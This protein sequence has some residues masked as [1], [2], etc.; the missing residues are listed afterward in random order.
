MQTSTTARAFATLTART[1]DAFDSLSL[2]AAALDTLA[3]VASC[4]AGT[5]VS[6]LETLPVPSDVRP[7]DGAGATAQAFASARHAL[8][9]AREHLAAQAGALAELASPAAREAGT[10]REAQQLLPA[11]LVLGALEVGDDAQAGQ[12]LAPTVAPA[13]AAE[14]VRAAANPPCEPA[15]AAPLVSVREV[16][17]LT[18]EEGLARMESILAEAKGLGAGASG[19]APLASP[20]LLSCPACGDVEVR[21]TLPPELLGV[22]QCGPCAAAGRYVTLEVV[23]HDSAAGSIDAPTVSPDAAIARSAARMDRLGAESSK[24]AP[25]ALAP[26]KARRMSKAD[27]LALAE[28]RGLDGDLLAECTKA[29]ILDNLGFGR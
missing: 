15:P 16:G 29:E 25:A 28:E 1:A 10:V 8:G 11:P 2:L 14:T 27:L 22:P 21:D 18:A 3:Y 9:A 24:G 26:A 19:P 12:G 5:V 23:A 4:E 13:P 6:L 17:L 7:T 20:V